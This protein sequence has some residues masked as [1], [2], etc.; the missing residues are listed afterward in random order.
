MPNVPQQVPNIDLPGAE[1]FALAPNRT[2]AMGGRRRRQQTLQGIFPASTTGN[3]FGQIAI[4]NPFPLT[5]GIYIHYLSVIWSPADTSGS[6]SIGQS[7]VGFTI[8]APGA[9]P[10]SFVG[11][12]VTIPTQT[13][14]APLGTQNIALERDLLLNGAD[15]QLAAS[16]A[17]GVLW[18]QMALAGHNGDAAN[19]HTI[20]MLSFLV[21]SRLDGFLE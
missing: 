15:L 18:W 2:I 5:A 8:A 3:T 13:N 7:S 12:N 9:T 10:P 1:Y 21:Y 14:A 6:V 19:P 16:A 17:P 20:N 11:F 4:E